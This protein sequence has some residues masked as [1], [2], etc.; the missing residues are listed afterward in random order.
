[1]NAHTHTRAQEAGYFRTK[2]SSVS[3][4]KLQAAIRSNS[5]SVIHWACGIPGEAH[6]NQY[7]LDWDTISIIQSSVSPDSHQFCWDWFLFSAAGSLLTTNQQQPF[8]GWKKKSRRSNFS[9]CTK[10]IKHL[11]K[12][13]YTSCMS[14]ASCCSLHINTQ[15]ELQTASCHLYQGTRGN[16]MDCSCS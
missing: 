14:T 4:Q 2:V 8:A 9:R 11:H 12:F 3:Q 5:L 7:G 13:S 10:G 15:A 16:V 1:M 6:V